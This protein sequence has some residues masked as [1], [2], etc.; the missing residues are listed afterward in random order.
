MFSTNSTFSNVTVNSDASNLNTDFYNIDSNR[1][2]R[3]KYYGSSTSQF[4][5][6]NGWGIG[7][8]GK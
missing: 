3:N 5:C 2:N 1:V 4:I 8:G 6:E 7:H